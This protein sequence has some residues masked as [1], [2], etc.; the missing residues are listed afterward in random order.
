MNG[1][2]ADRPALWELPSRLHRRARLRRLGPVRTDPARD[3]S[4]GSLTRRAAGSAAPASPRACASFD[5]RVTGWQDRVAA[6][7]DAPLPSGGGGPASASIAPPRSRD[8]G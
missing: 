4:D 8:G 5:R 6:A 1:H 3:D 7:Y 2:A